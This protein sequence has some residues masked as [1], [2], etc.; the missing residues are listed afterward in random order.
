MYILYA[1]KLNMFWCVLTYTYRTTPNYT[2]SYTHSPLF[3][4]FYM[5]IEHLS[6][7]SL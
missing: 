6:D 1:Y 3:I 4:H 7:A 5:Y 2:Y